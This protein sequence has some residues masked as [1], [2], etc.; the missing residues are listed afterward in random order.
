MSPSNTSTAPG[1]PTQN[2]QPE[3][4]QAAV[5]SDVPSEWG[6][7]VPVSILT[8]LSWRKRMKAKQAEEQRKLEEKK[9]INNHSN[10]SQR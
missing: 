9:Q 8:S 2:A 7:L 5:S 4:V 10:A 6:R 3:R 1:I